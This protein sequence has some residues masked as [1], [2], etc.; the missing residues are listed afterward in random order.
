MKRKIMKIISMVLIIAFTVNQVSYGASGEHIAREKAASALRPAS[1]VDNSLFPN[2]TF[3]INPQFDGNIGEIVEQT[4]FE[5]SG[6]PLEAATH[7]PESLV[8]R[9]I[10]DFE[11]AG[12]PRGE[13]N[14]KKRYEGVSFVS[15]MASI[16]AAASY[17]LENNDLD[18]PNKAEIILLRP[19]YGCSDNLFGQLQ[20]VA[21]VKFVN[22]LEELKEAVTENTV[23]FFFESPANPS[24]KIIPIKKAADIVKSKNPNAIV[25]FDNTFATSAAQQPLRHGVDISMVGCT[26]GI[27]AV[28]DVEGAVLVAKKDIA[29][30]LKSRR[31]K[32]ASPI[33]ALDAFKI[34]KYGLPFL[35]KRLEKQQSN[36]FK[37]VELLKQKVNDGIIKSVS[38]PGDLQN[39]DYETA[40]AQM[41]NFGHMIYF[42]LDTLERAK[43]CVNLTKYTR[44]LNYAVSLGQVRTLIEVPAL[45]THK[46]VSKEDQKA[47]GISEGGVRL[48]VGIENIDDVLRELECVF[49]ILE[50]YKDNLDAIP[51]DKLDRIFMAKW[52]GPNGE[53]EH[54]L[55]KMPIIRRKNNKYVIEPNIT[56]A[57]SR[58]RDDYTKETARIIHE[59]TR[60]DR[61]DAQNLLIHHTW[62]W[63]LLSGDHHSLTSSGGS[64]TFRSENA[65]SMED[66]FISLGLLEKDT[67]KIEA[68]LRNIY[69]RLGTPAIVTL[70]T[71][72]TLFET[73]VKDALSY[74]Y[75][76]FSTPS[77]NE[78]INCVINKSILTTP[79]KENNKP[80]KIVAFTS[81]NTKLDLIINH[82]KN[83]YYSE[84]ENE[85]G[86]LKFEFEA[87]YS[88][89]G[90]AGLNETVDFVFVDDAPYSGLNVSDINS[91]KQHTNA[92]I[93]WINTSGF[94]KGIQPIKEGADMSIVSIKDG[95]EENSAV[96]VAPFEDATKFAGTRKNTDNPVRD[97]KALEASNYILPHREFGIATQTYERKTAYLHEETPGHVFISA[98]HI[99]SNKSFPDEVNILGS[100]VSIT[101]ICSTH[102][103]ETRESVNAPSIIR[104][105]CNDM[106][107]NATNQAQISED[108][109]E[110]FL[111]SRQVDI[112][113]NN[114]YTKI[115]NFL[116]YIKDYVLAS[117]RK[118]VY[119]DEVKKF[120]D[121]VELKLDS[122]NEQLYSIGTQRN[123]CIADCPISSPEDKEKYD[124]YFSSLP[125]KQQEVLKESKWKY[126]IFWV[127]SLDGKDGKKIGDILEKK[128]DKLKQEKLALVSDAKLLKDAIAYSKLK[129]KNPVLKKRFQKL[130]PTLLYEQVDNDPKIRKQYLELYKAYLSFPMVYE[131][132]KLNDVSAN[133][134]SRN[135]LDE[136]ERKQLSLF[137]P[138][139]G[140]E[141]V[142]RKLAFAKLQNE[143][144][145]KLATKFGLSYKSYTELSHAANEFPYSQFEKFAGQIETATKHAITEAAD[146]YRQALAEEGLELLPHNVL[147]K[148]RKTYKEVEQYYTVDQLSKAVKQTFEDM[149]I[150]I[151]KVLIDNNTR[152]QEGLEGK[153]DG[154]FPHP[155]ISTYIGRGL[156]AR[157]LLNLQDGADFA[158]ILPHETGHGANHTN[159]NFDEGTLVGSSSQ[160]ISEFLARFIENMIYDPVWIQKYISEMPKPLMY[161][162]LEA[163]RKEHLLMFRGLG[164][165]LAVSGFEKYM[166]ELADMDENS[167]EYKKIYGDMTKEQALTQYYWNMRSGITGIP[168]PAHVKDYYNS[169]EWAGLIHYI[170]ATAYMPFS[171]FYAD[172]YYYQVARA[173]KDKGLSIAKN[174]KEI[175]KF[176]TEKFYNVGSRISGDEI[177]ENAIGKKPDPRDYIQWAI[178]EIK[179]PSIKEEVISAGKNRERGIFDVSN[180]LPLSIIEEPRPVKIKQFKEADMT[181]ESLPI[182]ELHNLVNK[183]GLPSTTMVLNAKDGIESTQ[184]LINKIINEKVGVALVFCDNYEQAKTFYYTLFNKIKDM[185]TL[186]R[187]LSALYALKPEIAESAP[188][189]LNFVFSESAISP[190]ISLKDVFYTRIASD[191]DVKI[192]ITHYAQEDTQSAKDL[193]EWAKGRKQKDA[194]EVAS[195]SEKKLLKYA[196][197]AKN[198]SNRI[199]GIIYPAA[200]I[201]Q[202]Q[203]LVIAYPPHNKKIEKFAKQLE[204]RGGFVK[205]ITSISPI[206]KYGFYGMFILTWLNLMDFA[207]YLFEMTQKINIGLITRPVSIARDIDYEPTGDETYYKDG[208]RLYENGCSFDKDGKRP[209]AI[210]VFNEALAKF[211]EISDQYKKRSERDNFIKLT[212]GKIKEEWQSRLRNA[213]TLYSKASYSKAI[214]IFN[215]IIANCKISKTRPIIQEAE[216]MRGLA[217]K[218]MVSEIEWCNKKIAK[219]TSDIETCNKSKNSGN[220]KKFGNKNEIIVTSSEKIIEKLENILQHVN[221]LD[222]TDITENIYNEI[223]KAKD[224]VITVITI[225]STTQKTLKRLIA[226]VNTQL[227]KLEPLKDL[228]EDEP[229]KNKAAINLVPEDTPADDDT[230]R[231]L[232]GEIA[233]AK[234]QLK[235]KYKHEDNLRWLFVLHT[236]TIELSK[237]Q[238][239]QKKVE[240][241]L[242]ALKTLTSKA[243]PSTSLGKEFCAKLG[244]ILNYLGKYKEARIYFNNGILSTDREAKLASL[245]GLAYAYLF[246][247]DNQESVEAANILLSL[248]ADDIA[249]AITKAY[250]LKNMEEFEEAEVVF[251]DLVR[252]TEA[253]MHNE[254]LELAPIK[255][256][257]GL[258]DVLHKQGKIDQAKLEIKRAVWLNK[259]RKDVKEAVTALS[260][261][262]TA[263]PVASRENVKTLYEDA[264]KML[265]RPEECMNALRDIFYVIQGEN[266]YDDVKADLHAGIG[267]CFQKM[268]NN[269]MAAFEFKYAKSA[270]VE[271]EQV[272]PEDLKTQAKEKLILANQCYDPNDQDSGWKA[273]V[274]LREVIDMAD[275]DTIYDAYNTLAYIY[276]LEGNVTE[277][278]LLYSKMVDL[279]LHDE[280]GKCDIKTVY[281]R[282]GVA[283]ADGKIFRHAPDYIKSLGGAGAT[284]TKRFFSSMIA[285]RLAQRE[286]NLEKVI[287]EAFLA[288]NHIKSQEH[289][290]NFLAE[291][292]CNL[293]YCLRQQKIT[294]EVTAN[295]K[296]SIGF[297]FKKL[298]LEAPGESD[299][300][301]T[302][303]EFTEKNITPHDLSF[304]ERQNLGEILNGFGAICTD[305]GTPDLA[306]RFFVLADKFLISK[307]ERNFMVFLRGQAYLEKARL[308]RDEKDAGAVEAFSLAEKD[309]I[310]SEKAIPKCRSFAYYLLGAINLFLNRPN[311]AIGY[312]IKAQ[313]E[314]YEKSYT[315][316]T[317]LH[318]NLALNKIDDALLLFSQLIKQSP[319]NEKIYTTLLSGIH[320]GWDNLPRFVMSMGNVPGAIETFCK[321][322]ETEDDVEEKNKMVNSLLPI[323][324][325]TSA[326][327]KAAITI[328]KT[329]NM[330][331]DTRVLEGLLDSISLQLSEMP[332]SKNGNGNNLHSLAEDI[333]IFAENCDNL[334]L[335]ELAN[336]LNQ[337]KSDNFYEDL[338]LKTSVNAREK[339]VQAMLLQAPQTDGK[340]LKVLSQKN[341]DQQKEIFDEYKVSD[342]GEVRD[343]ALDCL[344]R[345]VKEGI[346]LKDEP[347]EMRA[348]MELV[349]I[350]AADNR[351]DDLKNSSYAPL[352]IVK[353]EGMEFVLP[354][355]VSSHTLSN[356]RVMF[357]GNREIDEEA[358][359]LMKKVFRNGKRF[360]SSYAGRTHYWL[361][362]PVEGANKQNIAVVA[363]DAKGAIKGKA[364]EEAIAFSAYALTHLCEVDYTG[365]RKIRDEVNNAILWCKGKIKG[366]EPKVYFDRRSHSIV[367][368]HDKSP[369]M[370]SVKIEKN[371]GAV[372]SERD[373]SQEYIN[374]S[375]DV[376][377]I[378]HISLPL[379]PRNKPRDPTESTKVVDLINKIN[380][381]F[382]SD[383][384]NTAGKDTAWFYIQ[385]E[386]LNKYPKH[387]LTKENLPV[388]QNLYIKTAVEEIKQLLDARADEYN[389]LDAF[390]EIEKLEQHVSNGDLPANNTLI[391]NKLPSLKYLAYLAF[392]DIPKDDVLVLLKVRAK[393]KLD[394]KGTIIDMYMDLY[395]EAIAPWQI[396]LIECVAE[397]I[398]VK[399]GIKDCVF[400]LEFSDTA[401]LITF[402]FSK[403]DMEN[404]IRIII[405]ENPQDLSKDVDMLIKQASAAEAVGV[406][407]GSNHR[408][409]T[410]LPLKTAV[411][412]ISRVDTVISIVIVTAG[413][414]VG[415]L[416]GYFFGVAVPFI[417]AASLFSI[418]GIWYV[419]AKIYKAKFASKKAAKGKPEKEETIYDIIKS[420]FEEALGLEKVDEK[421]E[422]LESALKDAKNNLSSISEEIRTIEGKRAPLVDAQ[423]QGIILKVDGKVKNIKRQTA[424]KSYS[425]KQK[426]NQKHEVV[427]EEQNKELGELTKQLDECNGLKLKLEWLI[428][429]IEKEFKLAKKAAKLLQPVVPSGHKKVIKKKE[430]P[431]DKPYIEDKEPEKIK[432]SDLEDNQAEYTT[433]VG[434]INN[435]FKKHEQRINDSMN[436][437]TSDAFE[438]SLAEAHKIRLQAINL[439]KEDSSNVKLQKALLKFDG[440][441]EYVNL[442]MQYAS[443]LFE[444]AQRYYDA[445]NESLDSFPSKYA[446]AQVILYTEL[447]G[448]RDIGAF[449][450]KA[451]EIRQGKLDRGFPVG[452][453]VFENNLKAARVEFAKLN[454]GNKEETPVTLEI[455]ANHL[456]NKTFEKEENQ[457][458]LKTQLLSSGKRL[459]MRIDEVGGE[460]CMDFD[461]QKYIPDEGKFIIKFNRIYN[462][463]YPSLFLPEVIKL[464][465]QLPGFEKGAVFEDTDG[466][467]VDFGGSEND[468]SFLK[469]VYGFVLPLLLFYGPK[470]LEFLKDRPVGLSTKIVQ[471]DRIDWLLT[472]LE[473]K[474]KDD[475]KSAEMIEINDLYSKAKTAINKGKVYLSEAESCLKELKDKSHNIRLISVTAVFNLVHNEAVNIRNSKDIKPKWE[476]AKTESDFNE[477]RKAIKAYPVIEAQRGK[478]LSD[479][480]K[481]RQRIQ[482]IAKQELLL[483]VME[484]E[485]IALKRKIESPSTQKKSVIKQDTKKTQKEKEATRLFDE[486]VKHLNDSKHRIFE[487]AKA[488]FGKSWESAWEESKTLYNKA[489]EMLNS[490]KMLNYC[491]IDMLGKA[492]KMLE[493]TLILRETAKAIFQWDFEL[494]KEEKAK[495]TNLKHQDT[496]NVYFQEQK[497]LKEMIINYINDG[498]QDE[499]EKEVKHIENKFVKPDLSTLKEQ[500][501]L[502][503]EEIARFDNYDQLEKFMDSLVEFKAYDKIS[504][505]V[506]YTAKD[507]A[508]L[509]ERGVVASDRYSR[510]ALLDYCRIKDGDI[511]KSFIIKMRQEKNCP[512]SYFYNVKKRLEEAVEQFKD[513]A[514]EKQ[515]I[516]YELK[517]SGKEALKFIKFLNSRKEEWAGKISGMIIVAVYGSINMAKDIS[518]PKQAALLSEKINLHINS[519]ERFDVRV[520]TAVKNSDDY[521][522]VYEMITQ[523]FEEVTKPQEEAIVESEPITCKLSGGAVIEAV[524]GIMANGMTCDTMGYIKIIIP[525]INYEHVFEHYDLDAI[526]GLKAT[527]QEG[528]LDATFTVKV[529]IGFKNSPDEKGIEK[530]TAILKNAEGAYAKVKLV[531]EL[532]ELDQENIDGKMPDGKYTLR[533][534]DIVLDGLEENISIQMSLYDDKNEHGDIFIWALNY[535]S[536]EEKFTASWLD[537]AE[538]HREE[539]LIAKV[540]QRILQCK[541]IPDKARFEFIIGASRGQTKALLD[542]E[543]GGD[544]SEF[545]LSCSVEERDSEIV[546]TV[547]KTD[548]MNEEVTTLQVHE[549][550][551][552][553]DQVTF[554]HV[555]NV[556]EE[557][558]I[559]LKTVADSL[560]KTT[561]E[562]DKHMY[563]LTTSFTDCIKVGGYESLYIRIEEQGR[564]CLD[565]HIE[566]F[567]SENKFAMGLPI[568]AEQ[569]D[570]ANLLCP[571]VIKLIKQMFGIKR[572]LIFEDNKGNIVD[573]GGLKKQT[574]KTDKKQPAVLT[575][576]ESNAFVKYLKSQTVCN[577]EKIEAKWWRHGSSNPVFEIEAG[578][579]DKWRFSYEAKGNDII[580]DTLLSNDAV[581]FSGWTYKG[582]EDADTTVMVELIKVILSAEQIPDDAKFEFHIASKDQDTLNFFNTLIAKHAPNFGLQC[583]ESRWGYFVYADKQ[584]TPPLTLEASK[585][586]RTMPQQQADYKVITMKF[587]LAGDS[588]KHFAWMS[589]HKDYS[590]LK[591]KTCVSS[592][593]VFT[594]AVK[595]KVFDMLKETYDGKDVNDLQYAISEN[596]LFVE[597][598]VEVEV[599]VK[600]EY[601]AETKRL[602]GE[603]LK[604][605]SNA[606]IELETIEDAAAAL[607]SQAAISQE[608]TTKGMEDIEINPVITTDEHMYEIRK[609]LQNQKITAKESKTDYKLSLSW[610]EFDEN[611]FE[612]CFY[613]YHNT[614]PKALVDWHVT[615]YPKYNKIQFKAFSSRFVEECK[616]QGLIVAFM[617]AINNA[618]N[619]ANTKFEFPVYAIGKDVFEKEIK[620]YLPDYGFEFVEGVKNWVSVYFVAKT[621][622]KDTTD[623]TKD[624]TTRSQVTTSQVPE[625]KITGK[626][627]D[628]SFKA[629]SEEIDTITDEISN[630]YKKDWE[631]KI[632]HIVISVDGIDLIIGDDSIG[633]QIGL[634]LEERGMWSSEVQV[635]LAVVF[636]T[637]PDDSVISEINSIIKKNIALK[638]KIPP[639]EGNV[640]AW[641]PN[642]VE[643]EDIE[644]TSFSL[645]FKDSRMHVR[646]APSL[647]ITYEQAIKFIEEYKQRMIERA[648]KVLEIPHL[649]ADF[650]NAT[651][652]SVYGLKSPKD[653]DD[654]MKSMDGA[655]N[656]KLTKLVLETRE[657]AHKD[658]E[659]LR[660]IMELLESCISGAKAVETEEVTSHKVTTSQEAEKITLTDDGK[661]ALVWQH[662]KTEKIFSNI[663][664]EQYYL[665]QRTDIQKIKES[666][667]SS[668]IPKIKITGQSLLKFLNDNDEIIDDCKAL[669]TNEYI[670]VYELVTTVY[671]ADEYA[672][673]YSLHLYKT[674]EKTDVNALKK[675]LYEI[676]KKEIEVQFVVR[677]S[678]I[679]KLEPNLKKL[680]D[681]FETYIE[682]AG[683]VTRHKSQDTR[684]QETEQAALTGKQIDEFGCYLKNQKIDG[685]DLNQKRVTY[686]IT[687]I[688]L[689]ETSY[690]FQFKI[691]IDR[692]VEEGKDYFS[693]DVMYDFNRKAFACVNFSVQGG[694]YKFI[695]MVELILNA[696][697][698]PKDAKLVYN[699]YSEDGSSK[700]QLNN[701]GD[702]SEYGLIHSAKKEGNIYT[703]NS[704]T[705][706]QKKDDKEVTKP[707]VKKK[708]RTS[709]NE[710]NGGSGFGTSLGTWCAAFMV[711]P[712]AWEGFATMFGVDPAAKLAVHGFIFATLGIFGSAISFKWW[713][714][715][716]NN[717]FADLLSYKAIP[718]DYAKKVK[719]VTKKIKDVKLGKGKENAKYNQISSSAAGL[720]ENIPSSV[721]KDFAKII[722]RNSSLD[723]FYRF[724]K[725]IS[726][727]SAAEE[728]YHPIDYIAAQARFNKLKKDKSALSSLGNLDISWE[729][730][731]LTIG[732]L[733]HS[734]LL[735]KEWKLHRHIDITKDFLVKLGY[736]KETKQ[737]LNLIKAYHSIMSSHADD[738]FL[739]K[740]AVENVVSII[741]KEDSEKRELKASMNIM[742]MALGEEVKE[743]KSEKRV[744]SE[745]LPTPE[746]SVETDITESEEDE[747]IDYTDTDGE[748]ETKKSEIKQSHDV[749]FGMEMFKKYHN[750]DLVFQDDG[751]GESIEEGGDDAIGTY[752]VTYNNF[753]ILA[754]ILIQERDNIRASAGYKRVDLKVVKEWISKGVSQKSEKE[755]DI[756][757][758]FFVE[759][760]LKDAEVDLGKESMSISV[761]VENIESTPGR[762][763]ELLN[764]AET[765][766]IAEMAKAETPGLFI[767][768]TVTA[769]RITPKDLRNLV[770]SLT[771]ELDADKNKYKGLSF[772]IQE[773]GKTGFDMYNINNTDDLRNLDNCI[774]AQIYPYDRP[775]MVIIQDSDSSDKKEHAQLVVKK[776]IRYRKFTNE[777]AKEWLKPGKKHTGYGDWLSSIDTGNFIFALVAILTGAIIWFFTGGSSTEHHDMI[778]PILS[779]GVGS[780]L[781]DSITATVYNL[782]VYNK[783]LEKTK[784]RQSDETE[785]T[786]TESI[787]KVEQTH[788]T[789]L[790][791]N[792]L[793]NRQRFF[794]GPINTFAGIASLILLSPFWAYGGLVKALHKLFSKA[795]LI[796]I[797]TGAISLF[798]VLKSFGQD[799]VNTAV[800]TTL[801]VDT[802][803]WWDQLCHGVGYVYLVYIGISLGISILLITAWIILFSIWKGRVIWATWE[804]SPRKILSNLH[805]WDNFERKRNAFLKKINMASSNKETKIEAAKQIHSEY[806]DKERLTK[807]YKKILAAK[808]PSI[809]EMRDLFKSAS[810]LSLVKSKTSFLDVKKAGE[811]LTEYLKSGSSETRYIAV[812]T[813]ILLASISLLDYGL[814][815]GDG[816]LPVKASELGRDLLSRVES[817]QEVM[818]W[819]GILIEAYYH[820]RADKGKSFAENL[821]AASDWAKCDSSAKDKLKTLFN[822][823]VKIIDG[824]TEPS[825]EDYETPLAKCDKNDVE[826]R[827]GIRYNE[828]LQRDKDSK[829]KY[830]ANLSRGEKLRAVMTKYTVK[831]AILAWLASMPLKA[832]GGDRWY[833]DCLRWIAKNIG[834]MWGLRKLVSQFII[835]TPPDV[836]EATKITQEAIDKEKQR[837]IGLILDSV[838]DAAKNKEEAEFHLRHYISMMENLGAKMDKSI[839]SDGKTRIDF[840]VK[841]SAICFEAWERDDNNTRFNNRQKLEGILQELIVYAKKVERNNND[842]YIVI[843]IDPEEYAYRD[844]SIEVYKKVID[845]FKG[846][847]G[848]GVKENP[849]I[850]GEK[851]GKKLL[852]I[853][854]AVQA[855]LKDSGKV[856]EQDLLAWEKQNN[857]SMPLRLVKGAYDEK[858]KKWAEK[859]MRYPLN[860]NI[861]P[862]KKGFS[863]PVFTNKESTDAH[864]ELLTEFLMANSEHFQIAIASHNYRSVAHAM[865]VADKYG[866]NKKDWRI[867]ML[868][869]FNEPGKDVYVG[870]GYQVFGYAPIGLEESGYPYVGRRLLEMRNKK[871]AITY[872]MAGDETFLE[873][874][875]KKPGFPKDKSDDPKLVPIIP[876]PD[877]FKMSQEDILAKWL[878]NY[879]RTREAGSSFTASG[880]AND[881][882]Q[883]NKYSIS[884]EKMAEILDALLKEGVLVRVE[885]QGVPKA[886]ELYWALTDV[887]KVQS[888]KDDT[889]IERAISE[890][891]VEKP[892]REEIINPK[893]TEK[894][895]QAA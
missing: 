405:K 565:W 318:A 711:I 475:P 830:W 601:A 481:Q 853:G 153:L 574:G 557:K 220:I 667:R 838:G 337:Y 202:K 329:L 752:S 773:K 448:S 164:Y 33:D 868:Y 293:A 277:A 553:D 476:N 48:S 802:Y 664:A 571:E 119:Y 866:L 235:Q 127:D 24:L 674:P 68:G 817:G 421:I 214:N 447:I 881:F 29:E 480:E 539:R 488:G 157:I 82:Y 694:I 254:P 532:E 61:C 233:A 748:K 406:K 42:D 584:V 347:A 502:R 145:R 122:I 403:A 203:N 259:E 536:E 819:V 465:M 294:D 499:F 847:Y 72:V 501:K 88:P 821:E 629:F 320:S 129:I 401:Q 280:S 735:P 393:L 104:D 728:S 746:I 659:E 140:K 886:N 880:A 473:E 757:N 298:G 435:L 69:T 36:A 800:N 79:A 672:G 478:K 109:I 91:I 466:N 603:M 555:S 453:S 141:L 238:G 166:Y 321:V 811:R 191:K 121:E 888:S 842:V 816:V 310:S 105:T 598:G 385:N 643:G 518:D 30:K 160:A 507:S 529:I 706:I 791:E 588:L 714:E 533:D 115:I 66:A 60:I 125:D 245:E 253:K 207:Y 358:L 227:E 80:I 147:Y 608:K 710:G 690:G 789:A 239:N 670:N 756:T 832:L 736:K 620:P 638:T 828:I 246:T 724:L 383:E 707:Q 112:A 498:K 712:F 165:Y 887:Q 604:N 399:Q 551:K 660:A 804:L 471:G 820:H 460:K 455:I 684:S 764:E 445:H 427:W 561:L 255:A 681:I 285:G 27:S 31:A 701:F 139:R 554:D 758:K 843:C 859:G 13:D 708:K 653:A 677:S 860:K 424:G 580:I 646:T 862:E 372:V 787:K 379:L 655:Y 644:N 351:L 111:I 844:F 739:T 410:S 796:T 114:F 614:E 785:Y 799:A 567:P 289:S 330:L 717:F 616:Q 190:L 404:K 661:G 627:A 637:E 472:E 16:Y 420:D 131:G 244:S 132:E 654:I 890:A 774:Y 117:I 415:L 322:A 360:I 378:F 686:G 38:Y 394:D 846:Q 528:K 18:D 287:S 304:E 704:I 579:L 624:K 781:R 685:V 582:L 500:A 893:I 640:L 89:S 425:R 468:D 892:R 95:E 296:K 15:G 195:K 135:K 858:E 377:E 279:K 40:K 570:N 26:K 782:F 423:R 323:L 792:D 355:E 779:V 833:N 623:E 894:I 324:K 382:V 852:R 161:E 581:D 305:V 240:R 612:A 159:G 414:G 44:F 450:K 397:E 823:L 108:D 39:P 352:C 729:V 292:Y 562:K 218:K 212:E 391:K 669:V 738:E 470:I 291:A 278:I 2:S 396:L 726:V 231:K 793:K 699:V 266:G 822:A 722:G 770:K 647:P 693:C 431:E 665:I 236:R 170:I 530:I 458:E 865:A 766:K 606:K 21:K 514:T 158:Y 673:S 84:L 274:Y 268:H 818:R 58:L 181:I 867:E 572:D 794:Y 319:T 64:T 303:C 544:L 34:I 206:K 526:D 443:W 671:E 649:V 101:L 250:A 682:G 343:E 433:E 173:L 805:T 438:T 658:T 148:N 687:V 564:R 749:T 815:L 93:T 98:E 745:E 875:R 103:T 550:M 652:S 636:I 560:N 474:L 688:Y 19:A 142:S 496:M 519:T 192:I 596:S 380:R 176:L 698:I 341:I 241:S 315:D 267:I 32:L 803:G 286:G 467:V 721:K 534:V 633:K 128:E 354:L 213:N 641:K 428:P 883:E 634:R 876:K 10:A 632:R 452:I 540:I 5:K 440:Y 344:V 716:F 663:N 775:L 307:E 855:Y 877:V 50:R 689:E 755:Y 505:I 67:Q 249:G 12:V 619:M 486:F 485:I 695:K 186:E 272:H 538:G 778:L 260:V 542:P 282:M 251:N 301:E 387:T 411:R 185:D 556:T 234:S 197:V 219:L 156:A 840:A 494:A 151:S 831:Y 328:F 691:A 78:A 226:Y 138:Q 666:E 439:A 333:N 583:K 720:Y 168:D 208:V 733:E 196:L 302:F 52:Y 586:Q 49:T 367:V 618:P 224:P 456:N 300:L 845:D 503:E 872:I 189:G 702:L 429:K 384:K 461:I 17:A 346:V 76:G 861:S 283:F 848:D 124:T 444:D 342:N 622:K 85:N 639:I 56:R 834:A 389:V 299:N 184:E 134:I 22:S 879:L 469:K 591:N 850:Y 331:K 242:N 587:T 375:D 768:K 102:H 535:S 392:T 589:N 96:I 308:L 71:L 464:I 312:A 777:E 409:I 263:P 201:K 760:M 172:I 275:S 412:G 506:T 43:A 723:M 81:E 492:N 53:T 703:A 490:S 718:T 340:W 271:T 126:P 795:V 265:D 55:R 849:V 317:L 430:Q 709:G 759:Q 827:T 835:P 513:T 221:N 97:R 366:E 491:D 311:D 825:G 613:I 390:L 407:N 541:L 177:I 209:E 92:K 309:L 605:S 295:Y 359:L 332:K 837:Q 65:K 522:A 174:P 376:S 635:T 326:G 133:Y 143:T 257:L 568:R 656:K 891:I 252:L 297:L 600:S 369:K 59:A 83:Q 175:G 515:E 734:M 459:Y 521:K 851:N 370:W 198:T 169:P 657:Q 35:Y 281:Y 54:L 363:I 9:M 47:G 769:W 215:D 662:H 675:L 116:K 457:Y 361:P 648:E 510:R 767:G 46:T 523:A 437:T 237:I 229:I 179:N 558:P 137:M 585:S 28:G 610:S 509:L 597:Q 325:E 356:V 810:A 416:L 228:E 552:T 628:M 349:A 520:M 531:E 776:F 11:S 77:L 763:I 434:K 426:I 651:G 86:N 338:M 812:D 599:V 154:R 573:F 566:Y 493:Q 373:F 211:N 187:V 788:N 780:S 441:S 417:V 545:G 751:E 37:V 216:R 118:T 549:P 593:T 451:Q 149:G 247:N 51:Y 144:T 87:V 402:D 167:E 786:K 273:K 495:L 74:K 368:A 419:A 631:E 808:L 388:F 482:K 162:F 679:D 222:E 578:K 381:C 829:A 200:G 171:Y 290:Y 90:I 873:D 70:E 136:K 839:D 152:G 744:V 353:E 783:D 1:L 731:F 592:F 642:D 223:M 248:E 243:G 747:S 194:E 547:K 895:G 607:P 418:F 110:G 594:Q 199:V 339:I 113:K 885:K 730:I 449:D 41:T 314:G 398:A 882:Q 856:L 512:L 232:E 106:I 163:R 742:L 442:A 270:R 527:I 824:K 210:Q 611:G 625:T 350:Y 692:E 288:V 193:I 413:L 107:N 772:R 432:P 386:L 871:N 762:V 477:L 258:A 874:L 741:T 336:L 884:N 864:F 276:H 497:K 365:A 256:L 809:K 345:F 6:T 798:G 524:E 462:K 621:D 790:P 45:G 761:I 334:Q 264:L 727:I 155:G 188:Q 357:K 57:I 374:G 436:Y 205:E 713:K 559:S 765:G 120:I 130:I 609:F 650:G 348:A 422:A 617:Q 753:C 537:M 371:V 807:R 630:K 826:G 797:A 327:K 75:R 740:K 863:S 178:T 183:L 217:Y 732:L 487:T 182:D 479:H 801:V 400:E 8:E 225:E 484:N 362:V 668:D 602:L 99:K 645:I 94:S 463:D 546:Y 508:E 754:D 525:G 25:A 395:K 63:G 705:K 626:T 408:V 700:K 7:E 615:Y 23:F 100:K 204:F 446:N 230:I 14:K 857:Y 697:H 683:K 261:E 719:E 284:D 836:Q 576:E 696:P 180:F 543:L 306:I 335:I 150:D 454:E 313:K 577:G 73:G 676:G 750:P 841:L 878:T 725:E 813:K 806:P 20:S 595:G 517:L 4:V 504:V 870:M 889:D 590:L 771:E 869:G 316:I 678:G 269:R 784:N 814:I 146:E 737:V 575:N 854:T 715:F 680:K 62:L 489:K 743:A 511:N 262:I 123:S 569:M 3:Q 563:S 548:K 483:L 516:N 364:D